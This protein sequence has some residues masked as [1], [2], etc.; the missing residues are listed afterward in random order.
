LNIADFKC[1]R[2]EKSMNQEMSIV[3]QQGAKSIQNLNKRI[4]NDQRSIILVRELYIGTRNDEFMQLIRKC[5]RYDQKEREKKQ[6]RIH[7]IL[8]YII[9]GYMFRLL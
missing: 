4:I 7:E 8:Y 1:R 2:K 9:S 6:R 3:I 5:K